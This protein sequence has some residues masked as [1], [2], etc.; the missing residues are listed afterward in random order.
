MTGEILAGKGREDVYADFAEDR[1]RTGRYDLPSKR[2]QM[3]DVYLAQMKLFMKGYVPVVLLAMIVAIPAIIYTGVLD[4]LIIDHTRE[5]I[6]DTGETYVAICLGLMSAMMALIASIVCGSMLPAEFKHRT[7]YINFPI[8]QSRSVFYIGKFLAGYTL[9]LV[10]I[11]LAFAESVLMATVAG[12]PS[13]STTAVAEALLLAV[14]GSFAFGAVAYG[15]SAFMTSGSTMLPFS[16][17]FIIVPTLC[18]VLFNGMGC[19][20]LIGYVP[21]FSGDLALACLGSDQ[22][23]SVSMLMSDITVDMSA[24]VPLAAAIDL[25]AGLFFLMLGLSKTKRREI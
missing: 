17:L 25:A 22:T 8:P 1:H 21:V 7:A 15:I 20:N 24:S 5:S 10:T 19:M 18:L 16:I 9:I 6:G 2:R 14:A 11:L 4:D 13:V 12:Y 23:L 3:L